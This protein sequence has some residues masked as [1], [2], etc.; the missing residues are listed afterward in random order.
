MKNSNQVRE[1]LI[2]DDG[3]QIAEVV[4]GP[5]GVLTGSARIAW[6]LEE[7]ANAALTEEKLKRKNKEIETKKRI[8][9]EKILSLRSEF[10]LVKDELNHMYMQGELKKGITQENRKKIIGIR[11]N[12]EKKTRKKKK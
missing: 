11:E 5:D 10:E 9:E 6:E 2:T 3:I 1:F 8:L 12:K 7:A 4:L